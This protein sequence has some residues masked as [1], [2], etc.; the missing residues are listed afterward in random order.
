MSHS[1]NG[2]QYDKY[3]TTTQ[4]PKITEH[5]KYVKIDLIKIIKS[6]VDTV[7]RKQILLKYT[8][9]SHTNKYKN[10]I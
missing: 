5:L 4:I 9:Y 1:N 8:S 2:V 3:S 10:I 6:L 7:A